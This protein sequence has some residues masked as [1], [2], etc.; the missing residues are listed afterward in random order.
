MADGGYLAPCPLF[1]LTSLSSLVSPKN[2]QMWRLE[3]N[4]DLHCIL[5]KKKKKKN[6]Y[7]TIVTEKKTLVLYAYGYTFIPR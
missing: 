7:W 2:V 6:T 5:S 1:V 4:G 3:K